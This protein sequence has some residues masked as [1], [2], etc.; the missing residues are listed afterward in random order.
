[1]LP[2]D[3]QWPRHEGKHQHGPKQRPGNV[4]DRLGNSVGHRDDGIIV[5]PRQAR[6]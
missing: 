6:V 5:G 1:M 4:H 3:S 2:D